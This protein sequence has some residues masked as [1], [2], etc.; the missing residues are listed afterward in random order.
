[1]GV[2]VVAQDSQRLDA[3]FIERQSSNGDQM[4]LR[5]AWYFF[6]STGCFV[7]ALAGT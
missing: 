6:P 3:R 2:Q 5:K 7:T 4:T 1:M